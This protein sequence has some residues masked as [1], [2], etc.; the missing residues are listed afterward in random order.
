MQSRNRRD[1]FFA[2]LVINKL[3]AAGAAVYE[4]GDC[5]AMFALPQNALEDALPAIWFG[6][7][8]KC[9]IVKEGT[10][11]VSSPQSVTALMGEARVKCTWFNPLM[12]SARVSC[13][14]KTGVNGQP[15][16]T[17]YGTQY[18]LEHQNP[19]GGN[20]HADVNVSENVLMIVRVY[21]VEVGVWLLD[22]RDHA[23]ATQL[24][25]AGHERRISMAATVLEGK[26][27][28][29]VPQ[30]APKSHIEHGPKTGTVPATTLEGHKSK[31]SKKKP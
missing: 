30:I 21:E 6:K 3:R 17:V 2:P 26:A 13:T 4:V 20:A 11:W 8:W 16:E 25:K 28:S 24:N 10:S 15:V 22:E 19:W 31:K 29:V 12:P 18:K 23:K 1:R 7:I 14:P 9:V 27:L 5:I